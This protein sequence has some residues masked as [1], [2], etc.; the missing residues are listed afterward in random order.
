MKDRT[1]REFLKEGLAL[2]AG[3]AASGVLGNAGTVSASATGDGKT[4][5]PLETTKKKRK[6]YRVDHHG[7]A[8]AGSAL[9]DRMDRGTY[10]HYGAPAEPWRDLHEQFHVCKRLLT[11]SRDFP[12]RC[13]SQCARR[14]AD[15]AESSHAV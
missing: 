7:P 5:S 10:A 14:H 3:V 11:Q 6:Q 12:F 1:R 4:S 9:A 13:V 15:P 8:A 2:T